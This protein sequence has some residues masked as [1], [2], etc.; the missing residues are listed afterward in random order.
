[1]YDLHFTMLFGFIVELIFALDGILMVPGV[2][3]MY[4]FYVRGCCS[5]LRSVFR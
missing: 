2:C 1:M 4:L 5:T 3:C